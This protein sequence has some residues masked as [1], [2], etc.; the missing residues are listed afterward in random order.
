MAIAENLIRPS[1]GASSD[2]AATAPARSEPLAVRL[3]F[4]VLAALGLT[5]LV[6]GIGNRLTPDL[7]AVAPPVDLIPPLSDQAWFGAFSLHQQDPV[8]A[9]CGGSE[10]LAQFKLLYWWEWLRRGSV[11]LI[12][13]SFAAGFFV[14]ALLSE[15][16]FALKR[17]AV[18]CLIGLGYLAAAW[19]L[20]FALPR[21]ADLVRYN[22]GQYRHALDMTFAGVALA[23]VLA[24]AIAPPAAKASPSARP[25]RRAGWVW[26]ALIIL[27]ISSGA[28]FASRDAITVWRAFPGYETGV[29]PPLDRLTA[30]EP[31]WLNFTFNQ[32][33]IQLVHRILSIGLW[34]ALIGN[35]IWTGRR[36]AR[37]FAGVGVLLVLAT[38]Q[39]AAGIATLVLGGSPLA[40]FLH[41]I[42]AMVLLAG[43]FVVLTSPGMAQDASARMGS[44]SLP[45]GAAAGDGACGGAVS[46][47]DAFTS[48]DSCDAPRRLPARRPALL[49]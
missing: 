38:A 40:S 5:A 7:F 47:D 41:E 3:Y 20:G 45:S 32:Y 35:V 14:A 8:F 31:L 22:T 15:Y 13:G 27:D 39:M 2:V 28:L 12:A 43:A 19:C 46:S 36:N 44:L 33:M 6:L 42:G 30:F 29:L 9:A 18:L 24:S 37:A 48:P 17:H 25:L 1:A 11:L 26:I 16:R 49:P 10:S 23:L 34:V 4:L 21:V